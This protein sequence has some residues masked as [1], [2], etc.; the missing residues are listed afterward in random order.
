[1][2]LEVKYAGFAYTPN[3]PVFENISFGLEQGE[4]LSILGRNGVGKSTLI[5]CLLNLL[6]MKTGRVLLMGK[7]LK[8][9]SPQ[10]IASRVGYV[11]QSLHVVFPFTV[12]EFVLMGRAPHVSIFRTPNKKD[13]RAAEQALIKTG[14]DR[15]ADKTIAEISGGERQMVMIARSIA[16]APGLLIFDE[17]TSH[18]DLANQLRVLSVIE[19]LSSEGISVIMTTHF[20]D[21]CFLLSQRIAIMQEGRFAAQGPAEEVLTPSNLREAYGIDIDVCYVHQAGRRVCIPRNGKKPGSNSAGGLC[22]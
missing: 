2:I 5:Q 7:D 3:R 17:P 1:M 14:L 15:L 12:F 22:L 21:H 13:Y 8:S 19:R 18:L 16:Q 4:I 6:T 11:P 9:I 20:P 10:K